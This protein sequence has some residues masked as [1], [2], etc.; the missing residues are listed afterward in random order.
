MGLQKFLKRMSAEPAVR[1]AEHLREFCAGQ[2][3]DR[4]ADIRPRQLV[5]V[6]GEISALRIVPL[7][8]SPWLQATL[9]DGSESLTLVWTGRR[10]IGGV[11]PGRRLIVEGRAVAP[12][13]GERRLTIYNPEY[14]L[15]P[16]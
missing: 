6:A 4:V 13:P 12:R 7:D 10:R 2:G 8:G 16:S 3:C 9:S 11:T 14:Q 15:L 5:R 1:D